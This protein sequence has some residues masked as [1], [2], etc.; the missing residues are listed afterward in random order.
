M[1]QCSVWLCQWCS[2]CIHN[3]K[4]TIL[5]LFSP[6]V[7]SF[8]FNSSSSRP[9]NSIPHNIKCMKDRLDVYKINTINTTHDHINPSFNCL[10]LS[11]LNTNPSQVLNGFFTTHSRHQQLVGTT[12]QLIHDML[13]V[14]LE[15]KLILVWHH[16]AIPF[17]V[18]WMDC[19]CTK[20]SHLIQKGKNRNHHCTL[21]NQLFQLILKGTLQHTQGL[22]V[23]VDL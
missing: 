5:C 9:V 18:V 13:L 11:C 22:H 6:L 23:C 14:W 21:T 4:T 10:P 7:P 8:F 2:I 12:K 17:I 3:N 19:L 1:L 20:D 15:E 16:N